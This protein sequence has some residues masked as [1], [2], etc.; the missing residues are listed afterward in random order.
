MAAYRNVLDYF[1]SIKL[2][3]GLAK[4]D[5]MTRY[6]G[7]YFG[8][9]WSIVSP[10]ITILVYWFVFEKGLRASAPTENTP[11]ILWFIS[12][13]IPWFFF[14]DSLN[15]ATNSFFEYSYLVKKVLF[16][17]SILPI[18]K[19]VSNFF[20]HFLFLVILVCLFIAYGRPF[21]IYYLQVL[22]YS[23][24]MFILLIAISWITASIILFFRDMGQ[25]ISILL[26]FGM[27]LTPI[28]WPSTILPDNLEP[29]F[30]L[31]PVY[32]IVEGYRDSM[33]N[34]IWFFHRYNQ[35]MYFWILTICLLFLGFFIFK[36]LKPHF[37][38]VL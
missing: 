19:I 10:I 33:I 27:W 14:S 28:A 36:K 16:R 15:G 18:V 2:I 31:N 13:I 8:V 23:F 11:F 30:K 34:H 38:D 12:G 6:I 29:F 3:M 24:S 25:I 21:S 22:Y 7:S 9:L 20:I 5:F 1:K 17:I 32:Y 37:S 4:R 35:T 26:Q